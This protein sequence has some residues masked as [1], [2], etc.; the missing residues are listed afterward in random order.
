V[1]IAYLLTRAEPVGGAQIHV[2]DL[3]IS[4]R[5]QGHSPAI[6]TSGGGP[7][8]DDCQASGIP[9]VIL[10]HLSAPMHPTRDLRAL[11]EVRAALTHVRPELVAAHSAKAG[12]LGRLAGRFLHVPVV[13]TVHGWACAPGTPRL[14]AAV[15]RRVE[16]LIAPLAS[17]IITVSEFDRRF[18]L[19][20][21]L[22]T[23]EQVVTVHN[24]VSDV[25]LALQADPMTMPARLVMV[26]RFDPQKDQATLLHALAGLL[27]R[28]WEL[29][30]IGD[31]PLRRDMEVL[32]TRLGIASRV[33]FLGQRMDVDQILA[34][35]QIAA[36]VSHWE[37][38]PLTILEAMRAGLPVVATAVGGVAE[39]VT[40][41]ETGF[42]VPRG[43]VELLRN[44]IARLVADPALRRRLG[45]ASRQSYEQF[46]TL[47]HSVRKTLAVYQEVVDRDRITM[48]DHRV[49]D[50]VSA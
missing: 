12:V 38:F 11:R 5:A 50:R 46:F 27:D 18:G 24:G 1:K 32:A 21:G 22:V 45:T 8:V 13:V 43:D 14:Q 49:A 37:G 34:R 10:Q 41:G 2:R 17:K 7:M 30:L 47:D 20:A 25:P 35:A 9:V 4:V 44:R 26:A 23:E 16:C 6:I 15:S 39:S 19:E 33:R 3:A 36:L 28:A 29:D 42:L 31:G 48:A 40:E